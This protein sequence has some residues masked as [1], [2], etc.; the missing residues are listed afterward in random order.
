M[1]HRYSETDISLSHVP[2]E[3]T[4][5]EFS[6]SGVTISMHLLNSDASS[7]QHLHQNHH[8]RPAVSPSDSYHFTAEPTSTQTRLYVRFHFITQKE[9][10]VYILFKAPPPEFFPSGKGFNFH[11]IF[12]LTDFSAS[13]ICG[14]YNI[15]KDGNVTKK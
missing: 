6:E 1:R 4:I 12:N 3:K 9:P 13:A 5:R 10:Y 15:V 11:L 14:Y 7:Q 2:T 8:F